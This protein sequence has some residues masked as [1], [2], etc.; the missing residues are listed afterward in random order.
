MLWSLTG[1]RSGRGGGWTPQDPQTCFHTGHH[2]WE[3]QAPAP[4]SPGS[5]A[6]SPGS[7]AISRAEL[8]PRSW[9]PCSS[10]PSGALWSASC[11][12][13][14]CSGFRIQKINKNN[15]HV[16]AEGGW[17]GQ[18]APELPAGIG[19][20]QARLPTW[21]RGFGGLSAAK[22][23]QCFCSAGF[24]CSFCNVYIRIKVIIFNTNSL[25]P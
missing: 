13:P 20:P 2:A 5:F 19:G 14:D 12:C 3:G 6:L 21:Q 17:A 25:C 24:I 23:A 7:F 8:G 22:N 16:A 4:L 15:R 1:E 18:W 11:S 9:S 10:P